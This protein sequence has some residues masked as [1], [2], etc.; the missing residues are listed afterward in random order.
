MY[1]PIQIREYVIDTFH[2][3]VNPAYRN[4]EEEDELYRKAESAGIKFGFNV[5]SF[6]TRE[7]SGIIG[8]V[9]SSANYDS[10]TDEWKSFYRFKIGATGRFVLVSD[11]PDTETDEFKS[12]YLNSALSMLYGALR[13]MFVQICAS[14]PY[15]KLMFP[16]I[17]FLPA[18]ADKL[19]TPQK[20]TGETHE[21]G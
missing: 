13:A 4:P 11:V 7:Q 21:E 10:E 5:S 6:P 15:P 8:M 9:V 2:Y 12:A 1:A 20:P 3:D 14:S 16:T 17:D 19:G 18:I